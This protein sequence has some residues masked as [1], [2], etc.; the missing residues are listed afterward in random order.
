M[1]A[2]HDQKAPLEHQVPAKCA[3]CPFLDKE[4]DPLSSQT[5]LYCQAPWWHPKHWSCPLPAEVC[6]A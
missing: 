1:S 4:H 2:R 6:R 3:E 5:H